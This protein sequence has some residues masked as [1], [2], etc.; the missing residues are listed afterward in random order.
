M[1][2][3]PPNSPSGDLLV[4]PTDDKN[5]KVRLKKE[6]G[7]LEGVA[8]I[9]GIIVGSGIF[10]SPQG[11]IKEAGSV[12]TSLLVWILCGLLSTVGALCYAELG[13][14]IPKSGGD[15]A[16]IYEAFGP[17]P[18]FLYLWDA[19]LIFVPTT[20]AIMGLTFA[21]YVIK[22]FFPECNPPEFSDRLIA[23]AVICFFTFINCY[24]VKGTTRVQNAFMFTKI[25][26]VAIIILSG[27]GYIFF[28]TDE[29]FHNV[30]EGGKTSP[31]KIAVAIYAGIF[32]YSGWNYLNFMTEELKNPY[33]NLPRAIYI[34]LPLVTA[35]YVLANIAYVAVL[36]PAQMIASEAIAVTFGNE[37][38]GF[39][40]GSVPILV[41]L[42]ALGGLSVHIMTSSRMCFVGARYGHFPT[43]LSHINVNKYTPTPS[44]VFLCILSLIM[45]CTNDINVLITYASFVESFFITLSVSG[46]LWLRYKQPNMTRPIKV[47]LVIPVAFVIICVFLVVLPI[48]E[49]PYEVGMGVL[50][51]LTG[52]PAYYLGVVCQN[53][54][55]W[56]TH[57]FNGLT[58]TIQK[59]FMSAKE[60]KLEEYEM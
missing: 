16:Y 32:S 1:E 37:I 45:L 39:L 19:M 15:Y 17:V 11:V 55:K 22:P 28:E 40:S 38:L 57:Y 29:N 36:T 3:V 14:S 59:L 44:L 20:N 7:L 51:T 53:K 35:I 10:I 4:S 31:G 27:I 58:Y 47:N 13:T 24:D 60:D 2:V 25:G 26:A 56:F 21:K 23:A 49:K 34:S 43:M 48:Y 8:I 5:E 9:I 52:F 30:F 6:L 54:P 50:I 46:L 42:S 12:G 41:A 18:A 33:V